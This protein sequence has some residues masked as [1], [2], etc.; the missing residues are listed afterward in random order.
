MVAK[1]KTTFLRNSGRCLVRRACAASLDPNLRF[2]FLPSQLDAW[3][4]LD[5]KKA[6]FFF[7]FWF[8][9]GGCKFGPEEM[10]LSQRWV[11]Y[12]CFQGI[13]PLSEMSHPVHETFRKNSSV[14][15]YTNLFR[16]TKSEPS[17]K[18]Q[19]TTY[20]YAKK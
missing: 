11:V 12:G 10:I 14:D 6:F 20:I 3:R 2:F 18:R 4:D 5:K 15:P 9:Y 16:A 8:M 7:F 13:T 17:V 19:E 1:T